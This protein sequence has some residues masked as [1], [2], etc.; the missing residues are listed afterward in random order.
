LNQ[1]FALDA[2]LAGVDPDADVQGAVDP[3][4]S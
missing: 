4:D 1:P 3:D 2:A